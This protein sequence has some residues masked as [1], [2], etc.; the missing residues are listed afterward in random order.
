[1]KKY[2]NNKVLISTIAILYIITT[3]S[4]S[5]IVFFTTN[6]ISNLEIRNQQNT[7]FYL[8]LIAIFAA[9]FLLSAFGNLLL[10]NK[11]NYNVDILLNKD[12]VNKISMQNSYEITNNKEGKYLTWV[13]NRIPEIRKLVFNSLFSSLLNFFINFAT[14]IALFFVSWKL[15]LVG[16]GIF[17]FS[18]SIPVFLSILAGRINKKYNFSQEKFVSS[19]FNVFNG[20]K[21]LYYLGKEDKINNFI[22]KLIN[23]WVGQI[24]KSKSK[25]ILLE[26]INSSFQ[27][28][29][30]TLFLFIIGVFIFYLNEPLST[31]F[32]I[33]SLFLNLAFNIREMMFLVQNL[34]SYK[35]FI[36]DFSL[37]RPAELKTDSINIE[38]IEFKN[39]SFSYEQK[40]ILKNLNIVFEK[41]KKYAIVAPSGFGKS[42]LIKLLLKQ[43]KDYS[44]EILINNANLAQIDETILFNSLT[45]LDNSE[46]L[47]IDSVHNNV[48][49]WE[50]SEEKF[51]QECLIKSD[52]TNVQPSDLITTNSS[53]ST[54]QKQKINIARHFYRNKNALICD[55]AFSNIDQ[56][57]KLKILNN[58]FS[59][60]NL[61]FINVSHH[62]SDLEI[63]DEII[64]LNERLQNEQ[65]T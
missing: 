28:F 52:L 55:E 47:F 19:L 24:D 50:N 43:I 42:T 5:L 12:I 40:D 15:T 23:D 51:I 26:V 44:G 48:A 18:F 21:M 46:N 7:N 17:I 4:S 20:F 35:D 63:Y 62:I 33:P 14:I 9:I 30:N 8:I 57:S 3:I 1:M 61:L 54:G 22:D 49:L 2:F 37:A 64:D 16:L 34:V 10:K 45:F 53:L 6:V 58:I 31:I 38:S 25:V 41:G 36:K 11:W 65:N 27:F 29:A 60:P 59:N 32:V 56:E 39:L 13:K